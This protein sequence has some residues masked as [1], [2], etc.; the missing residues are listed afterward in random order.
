MA[1]SSDDAVMR[2]ANRPGHPGEAAAVRLP[3]SDSAS[4]KPIGEAIRDAA[5]S[6]GHFHMTL[7]STHSGAP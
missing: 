4:L 2:P 5:R 1:D 3:L 6:P 7:M